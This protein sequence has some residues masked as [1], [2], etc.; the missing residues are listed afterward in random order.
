MAEARLDRTD[1]LKF[2]WGKHGYSKRY[3]GQT[4]A[5][6]A[7]QV[8][9]LACA[10]CERYFRGLR[11][12]IAPL[13]RETIEATW[14]AGVLHAVVQKCSCTFEDL[15]HTTN[16]EVARLVC[17]VSY[18]NRLPYPRRHLDL[19]SRLGEAVIPGQIL[20]LADLRCNIEAAITWSQENRARGKELFL[21]WVPRV[22]D[23]LTAMHRLRQSTTLLRYWEESRA[24]LDALSTLFTRSSRAPSLA[25]TAAD[26]QE[27]SS[28][29]VAPRVCAAPATRRRASTAQP[30]RARTRTAPAVRHKR[31]ARRTSVSSDVT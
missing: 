3:D 6:H 10:L 31:R 1:T 15:V 21:P 29:V 9:D 28:D 5:R 4:E 8:G 2:M 7:E 25:T 19:V 12:F 18:D 22:I 11:A 23:L 24:R 16:I 30:T 17:Q 27:V 20:V 14:H 13:D 26:H